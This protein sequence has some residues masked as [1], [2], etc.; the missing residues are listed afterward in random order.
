MAGIPRR[1]G[2][3]R[4]W[5]IAFRTAHIGVTGVLFGGH[6]FGM[7]AERLLPWLYL[8]ILTGAVLVIIE[9]YPSWRWCYQG[10]GAMPIAKVLVM[11]LVPWL[12][13]YRVPILIAVIVIGS[14]GSHMP[15]RFRYYSFLNGR[16]AD[17]G[18]TADWEKKDF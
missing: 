1:A 11:C 3:R 5:D 16:V 13:N 7:G 4:C 18:R 2:L 8:T 12:W 14:V 17:D 10:R 6:V 9:A 15:R